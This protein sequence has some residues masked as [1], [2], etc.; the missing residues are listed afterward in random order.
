MRV[1]VPTLGTELVL[2]RD[3]GFDLYD[4]HRN[5]DFIDTI[6][7]I[8][9][10]EDWNR[11]W[12]QREKLFPEGKIPVTLPEGSKLKVDRIYIRRGAGD[13]DSMTFW[14]V[15][16]PNKA[17]APKKVGGTATTRLRFWVKL[18]DANCIIYEQ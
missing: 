10:T 18:D 9:P 4:E 15:D 1:N 16:C 11:Y 7:G 3:W 17:W 8:S 13:F 5:R 6:A 14:L 12:K 2:S